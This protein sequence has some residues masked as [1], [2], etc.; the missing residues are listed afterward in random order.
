MINQLRDV[1]LVAATS[2]RFSAHLIAEGARLPGGRQPRRARRRD[3]QL[4]LSTE[5]AFA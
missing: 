5:D 3:G 2:G 4:R 1:K